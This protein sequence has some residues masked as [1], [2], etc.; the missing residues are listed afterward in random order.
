METS[1]ILLL[2]LMLLLP[3]SGLAARR[4]AADHVL[5]L[6]ISWTLIIAGVAIAVWLLQQSGWIGG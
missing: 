1:H 4:L 3:I 5:K 2:L 6:I